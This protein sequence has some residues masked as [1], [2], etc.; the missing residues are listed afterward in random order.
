MCD[1]LSDAKLCF[2]SFIYI[3]SYDGM[4]SICLCIVLFV[5]CVVGEQYSSIH[6]LL[7]MRVQLV[8]VVLHI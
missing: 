2:F 6:F 4:S 1:V 8:N 5:L 3:S 7:L